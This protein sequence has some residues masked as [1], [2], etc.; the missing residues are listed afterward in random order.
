MTVDSFLQ[1][2]EK[3]EIQVYEGTK[4]PKDLRK[5]HVCYV[6]SPQ[7]HPFDSN[8]LVL[9]TDPFST[10]T[11]YYDFRLDDIPYVEKQPNLTN[12]DGETV[13]MARVWVKKRSVGVHCTPFLVADTL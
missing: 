2:A 4:A 10:N 13:F 8:R 6:G 12:L 9:I 7:K 3:F 11:T 5:D 1:M